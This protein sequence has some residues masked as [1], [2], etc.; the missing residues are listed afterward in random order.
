MDRETKLQDI[1]S[2]KR[3]QAREYT[4]HILERLELLKIIDVVKKI[5]VENRYLEKVSKIEKVRT[6]K[7]KLDQDN[8]ELHKMRMDKR[9][10]RTMQNKELVSSISKRKAKDL[11]SKFRTSTENLNFKNEEN[12]FKS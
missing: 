5:E 1:M 3:N 9:F 11:N 7:S 12:A 10:E 6:E 2:L 8:L 4:D